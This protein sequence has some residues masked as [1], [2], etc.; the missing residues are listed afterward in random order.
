MSTVDFDGRVAVVTGA[1]GG[2]GRAHAHEL[3]RL[4]ARVVVNDLG[5]ARDGTGSGSEMADAVVAEITD[6]GGEAVA[7]TDGVHT[8]EGG[9]AIVQTALDTWGRI[10]VVVNNAGILRDVSFA[11]L[12][13][14][15]LDAVLKV[16]LSG[17]FHVTRAAWPHFREQSY[18]RV[19]MTSSGSG[20][21][22]NFGQ[23]N[24]AAAKLGLVGLTRTLAIEGAKYGIL[25]NAIAPVAASRMTEDI[26]PA[27]LLDKLQP[28]EVS[29]LVA[30]LTSEANTTTGRIYSVGGGYI[31]RVAI[32]EGTPLTFDHTP[33]V[34]EVADH[35]D[36]LTDLGDD[37]VEFTDGVMEQSGRIVSALGIDPGA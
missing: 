17:A 19:V 34:E 26:W 11:K 12:E 30:W 23:S 28:D 29:P 5:G 3:A 7:N 14:A 27:A 24:Y 31:A 8:W 9:Q 21:Y 6:A 36:Q 35:F 2:L 4:G 25:A 20:L 22:G 33:T 32:V 18:G 37:R 13:E 15:Q 16:H 10:D 1:G